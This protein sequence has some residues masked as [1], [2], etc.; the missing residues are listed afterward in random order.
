MFVEAELRCA[1][2]NKHAAAS[3][4]S[5]LLNELLLCVISCKKCALAATAEIPVAAEDRARM[6][7]RTTSCA[8]VVQPTLPD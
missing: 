5:G 3:F 2:T 4:I 7:S 1:A 6:F 8:G